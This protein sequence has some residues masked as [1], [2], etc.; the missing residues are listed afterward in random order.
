ML[1]STGSLKCNAMQTCISKDKL[2]Y[3]VIT[4]IPQVLVVSNNK[5]YFLV[6]LHIHHGLVSAQLS[7]IFS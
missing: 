5:V 4:N 7:N 3:A 1:A 6:M 2:G